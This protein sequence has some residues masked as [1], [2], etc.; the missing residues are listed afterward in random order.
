MA[1]PLL[2][3]FD[4]FSNVM[5]L[6]RNQ[7]F[8]DLLENYERAKKVFFVGYEVEDDVSSLVLFEGLKPED[9][10]VAFAKFVK[11]KEKEIEAIAILLSKPKDWNT[12]ALND[13]RKVLKE[14]S[15]IEYNLQRAHKLVYHKNLV[16]II[17]MVKHA[18]ND[19]EPLLT[20]EER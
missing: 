14:N 20:P 18:A 7:Q 6:L 16:D 9:Y 5:E 2:E 3:I 13:L 10:L 17:S 19:T 1:K 8:Q 4:S 11:Q 12:K 15:F